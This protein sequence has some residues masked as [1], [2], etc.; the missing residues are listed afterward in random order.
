MTLSNHCDEYFCSSTIID[1]HATLERS[2]TMARKSLLLIIISV[3]L[4]PVFNLEAAETLPRAALIENTSKSVPS[5]DVYSISAGTI[6]EPDIVCS[7]RIPHVKEEIVLSARVRGTKAKQ[8][9]SVVFTLETPGQDKIHLQAKPIPNQDKTFMD[10]EVHWQPRETGFYTVVV[11]VDPENESGDIFRDN[12]KAQILLPV[13][14]Q[15]LHTLSWYTPKYCRWLGTAVIT[16]KENREY[17]ELWHRRG[18]K[19]LSL[20]Y[21][22]YGTLSKYSQEKLNST[23]VNKI[24][25]HNS[26]GCDGYLVDELGNY[27]STE[28]LAYIQRVG[29]AFKQ[30]RKEFPDFLGYCFV[31]G[32]TLREQADLSRELQQVLISEAYP[33]YITTFFASHSFEKR[34][35][36]RFQVARNV[37]ALAAH[38]QRSC[39]ILALGVGGEC[40]ALWEPIVENRV[41]LYRRSAPEAPG[42]CFYPG[43]QQDGVDL[44]QWDDYQIFLDDLILK[45]FIKPVLMVKSSDLFLAKNEPEV[46]EQNTV[47]IRIHNIG[48]MKAKEIGVKMFARHLGSTKRELIY[49]TVL[50]EIGNGIVNIRKNNPLSYTLAEINGVTYPATYYRNSNS[51]RTRVTGIQKVFVDRAIVQAEWQPKQKGYYSIEAEISPSSNYTILDGF[52]QKEVLIK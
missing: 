33:E 21:M 31:S 45:Y 36:H 14:W 48:G 49:E 7:T 29:K 11:H 1:Q 43:G 6:E 44:K 52:V 30:V 8:P 23:I 5:N 19:V 41:R 34:L 38:G 42:I 2:S 18:S 46:G 17:I 27:P 28:G 4:S 16:F 50:P 3:L 51:S 9:T 13:T 35:D 47:V 26:W 12:N 39:S 37:D 22:R 25:Q 10:Y 20:L 15:E 24:K 32:G 40:G